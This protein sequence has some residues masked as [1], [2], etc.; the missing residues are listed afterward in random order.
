MVPC[1]YRFHSGEN[2]WP[3]KNSSCESVVSSNICSVAS[4]SRSDHSGIRTMEPHHH[5]FHIPSSHHSY[6]LPRSSS[7]HADGNDVG[8][9]IN[10]IPGSEAGSTRSHEAEVTDNIFDVDGDGNGYCEADFEGD[11]QL[12]CHVQDRVLAKVVHTLQQ[13]TARLDGDADPGEVVSNCRAIQACMDTIASIKQSRS[14]LL[15]PT[16]PSFNHQ[17]QSYYHHQQAPSQHSKL[18][19]SVHEPNNLIALAAARSGSPNRHPARQLHIATPN[20]LQGPQSQTHQTQ[21]NLTKSRLEENR[22]NLFNTPS[23]DTA[24]HLIM[25]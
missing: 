22:S 7:C 12:C 17:T 2:S 20:S 13:L 25:T 6:P 11:G 19:N 14:M 15:T 23:S 16:A 8:T 5:H 10:F 24:A 3:E 9:C 1:K 21:Q 4:S 18:G